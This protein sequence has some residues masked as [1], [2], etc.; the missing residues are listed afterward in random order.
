MLISKAKI[1]EF[2]EIYK[3][4]FGIEIDAEAAAGCANALLEL[5]KVV[6]KPIK[7]NYANKSK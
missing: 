2:Q 4:R 3:K 1:A 7:N 5:V 6:Y